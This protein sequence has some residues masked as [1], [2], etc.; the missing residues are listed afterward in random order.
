MWPHLMWGLLLPYKE[1][2]NKYGSTLRLKQ[3]SASFTTEEWHRQNKRD[4][5]H[6][7]IYC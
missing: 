1:F 3:A 5:E 6:K 4:T 2:V 7:N